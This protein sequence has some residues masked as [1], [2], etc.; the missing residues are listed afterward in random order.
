[1]YA[2]KTGDKTLTFDFAMGLN[3]NNLLFVDRESHS[4]WSQLDNKAISGPMKNTPLQIVPSIQATWQ[5]WREKYPDTK[6]MVVEDKKGRPYVYR[7]RKPGTPRP[8]ERPKQHD[9]SNLGLGMVVNE[10]A[11]FLSLNEL[12]KTSSPV[13]VEIGGQKVLIFHKEDALTAWAENKEGELLSGVL[14]YN[15]GWL[16]FFPE[17]EIFSAKTLVRK[18]H[19]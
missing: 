11:M 13:H 2:R 8:K 1:M 15:H 4:I 19:D 18:D 9:I 12:F 6:V 3:K 16:D 10:R 5:H 14:V 17:S 7:N